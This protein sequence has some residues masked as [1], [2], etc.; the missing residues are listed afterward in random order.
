MQSIKWVALYIL[1]VR[2]G[3]WRCPHGL[4]TG[5][6]HDMTYCAC[7]QTD[8]DPLDDMRFWSGD[9]EAREHAEADTGTRLER[10]C[11]R[12]K[13]QQKARRLK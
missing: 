6:V 4:I 1:Y 5:G 7:C 10:I 11:E 8:Y 12:C 9:Y 3:E 2:Q 13:R